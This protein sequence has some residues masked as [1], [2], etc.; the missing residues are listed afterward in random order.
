MSD[1]P[2]VDVLDQLENQNNEGSNNQQELPDTIV[3]RQPFPFM[4]RPIT[5]GVDGSNYLSVRTY[6]RYFWVPGVHLH[7]ALES[8]PRNIRYATNHI[9]R[10]RRG[11]FVRRQRRRLN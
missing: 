9:Y 7:Q 1:N 3:V 6:L 2:Y 8:R 4:R 11:R 10:T 5:L